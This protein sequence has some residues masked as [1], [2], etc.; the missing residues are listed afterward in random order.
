[1][2]ENGREKREKEGRK[3]DDG[4]EEKAGKWGKGGLTPPSEN[5]DQPL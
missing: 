3:W 2:R 5:L 1:M 4:E